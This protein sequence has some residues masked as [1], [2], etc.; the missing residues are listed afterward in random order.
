MYILR[1]ISILAP[2][3]AALALASLSCPAVLE[4][5]N[6]EQARP[7]GIDYSFAVWRIEMP[8][9]L[10]A[11][12]LVRIHVELINNGRRAWLRD[13]GDPYFLSFH[14]K[15]P[16]GRIERFWGERTPLPTPVGPGEIVAVEMALRTPEV[17]KYY[18]I[19]IDIVRGLG[20]DRD[21][22]YWFE[23]HGWRTH[24]L[25]VEVVEP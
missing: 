22:V 9:K 16:G 12:R 4:D 6:V 18:D 3:I 8:E 7:S 1:Q 19:T 24:D 5:V 13:S 21:S 25:R 11:G 2:A 17:P 15:H 14:W 10:P 23:E 20:E